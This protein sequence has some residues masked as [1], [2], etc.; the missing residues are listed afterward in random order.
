MLKKH[1]SFVLARRCRLTVSAAFTDMTHFI[2]RVVNLKAQRTAM[3]MSQ[4]P[5]GAG[6]K[7]AFW[8]IL[9]TILAL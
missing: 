4:S 5:G 6:K 7:V 9:R 3:A 1:A 8:S 2:Q